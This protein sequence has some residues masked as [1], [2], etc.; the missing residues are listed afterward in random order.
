MSIEHAVQKLRSFCTMARRFGYSRV[1]TSDQD[2]S[3]QLEALTKAGV[4]DRDIFREKASGANRQRTELRRMLDL[5]RPGDQAT[6][7]RLDRLARSQLHL[8]QIM[9]EIESKGAKLVSLMDNIDT[10]TATGKM[11][12]GVLAVLAEFEC[13]LLMERCA[14][15]VKIARQ[16]NVRFGRPP[17]LVWGLL[18]QALRHCRFSGL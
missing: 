3:L 2:W 15:G 11:V 12:V 6:V 7:Y 18:C 5:L 4:D 10:G 14:A 8:L 1:F 13:N 16:Q 9:E 17:K